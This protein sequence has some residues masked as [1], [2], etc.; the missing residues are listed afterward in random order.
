MI[1][2]EASE[3][4]QDSRDESGAPA[5]TTS[6]ALQ[7]L[8]G[9]LPPN[10]ADDTPQQAAA[11]VVVGEFRRFP[12]VVKLIEMC[13]KYRQLGDAWRQFFAGTPRASGPVDTV[14]DE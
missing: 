10:P 7:E 1:P 5:P 4:S 14:E 3:I 12:E 9:W 6:E 13:A 11:R 2:S 8:S